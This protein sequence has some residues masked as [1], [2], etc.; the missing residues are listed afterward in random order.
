MGARSVGADQPSIDID[1]LSALLDV[2]HSVFGPD[3]LVTV[4]TS[5]AGAVRGQSKAHS[6]VLA[7]SLIHI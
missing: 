7:L 6:A 2:A 5:L 3:T 4:G 1:D